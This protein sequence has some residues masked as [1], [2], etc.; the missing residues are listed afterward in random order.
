MPITSG[1]PIVLQTIDEKIIELQQKVRQ[2]STELILIDERITQIYTELSNEYTELF[3]NYEEL[4]DSKVDRAGDTM[5]GP[6]EQW[7]QNI[8]V[9]VV[10]STT[11][12]DSQYRLR[13]KNG[14]EIGALYAIRSSDDKLG[15][16][17][18]VSR[19]VNGTRHNNNIRLYLDN[20]GTQSVQVSNASAWQTALSV[21]P[22][23]GG[24]MTGNVYYSASGRG[25]YLKDSVSNNYPGVYDNGSNLWLGA[26]AT[27]STHHRGATY[28][29]AGFNG[30]SGNTTIYVCV[31]NTSNNNGTNYAVYHTGYKPSKSD[32]GLG[33]VTNQTETFSYDSNT[34]TL[35]ITVT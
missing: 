26:T 19:T 22:L 1:Q 13:D 20:A 11:Q 9:N 6:L 14:A 10:P 16:Q 3:N 23:A 24:T 18:E 33:K 31:P 30:S 32:V 21:L 7:S 12:W 25:W 34:K 17:M 2:I 27:A 5:T 28:I 35:T 8:D 29:S 4:S 15:M